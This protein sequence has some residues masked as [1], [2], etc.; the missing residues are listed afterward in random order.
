[1]AEEKPY[2]YYDVETDL[3]SQE[4]QDFIKFQSTRNNIKEPVIS[5]K[6]KVF[7]PLS[8]LLFDPT[9]GPAA[10]IRKGRYNKKISEGKL[11][12][13]TDLE[14]LEFESKG[15]PNR[16]IFEGYLNPKNLIPRDKKNEVEI[17]GD[18]ATGAVTGVPLGLKAIV[19]LLT[20]GIDTGSLI[21]FLVD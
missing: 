20:I 16:G 6:K 11:D 3:G 9:L 5:S 7:N 14:R 4:A 18:I 15:D 19:E 2:T 21:L 17:V 1:M 8:L 13:V 12:Q 10:W